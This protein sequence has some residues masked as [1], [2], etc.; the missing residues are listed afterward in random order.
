MIVYREL[1]TLSRDLGI[2]AK[3]LYAVSNAQDKHY[4]LIKIP[5]KDG[6]DRTLS[7]P[8]EILKKI[9]RAISEQ[10]LSREP[11]SRYAT[12]YRPA[13]GI[14]KNALPH[15]GKAKLLKLD[16]L[17]FFDSILYS[18]VKE[19]AFPAD[20]YSESNRIL[21]SMLCY[22][23]DTLPQGAPSSPA[24]TN[25]IMRDFD[26]A[27]GAWCAERKIAYTRY[28]DDMSFSGDFDEEEVIEYIAARLK[29]LGFTLNRRKTVVKTNSQ[30][31]TVTGIVVN[32]KPNIS[33]KYKREIRQAVFYCTKFGVTEHQKQI[34][35][36]QSPVAYLQALLG[37]INYVLQVCPNDTSFAAYRKSVL[38]LLEKNR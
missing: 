30:Q 36:S 15:V 14:L 25:I 3:T 29:E 33:A 12:A 1:S 7:I 11:I 6:T 16:I 37:K 19:R 26:E 28:C 13:S 24:I 8:D 27:V 21:L 38:A 2:P 5:K 4:R 22:Y 23:R 32:Q 35:S 18:A 9:Q 17:H 34:G 20:R 31:Q 10:L